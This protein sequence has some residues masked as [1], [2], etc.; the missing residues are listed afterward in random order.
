M[1]QKILS[2]ITCVAMWLSLISVSAVAAENIDDLI[3]DNNIEEYPI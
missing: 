1:K 3:S 2:V